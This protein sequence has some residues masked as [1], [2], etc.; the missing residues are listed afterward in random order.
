MIRHIA[1]DRADH[2][3]DAVGCTRVFGSVFVASGSFALAAAVVGT[4]GFGDATLLARLG[5]G[6]IGVAHLGGGL[7]LW[8][9]RWAGAVVRRRGVEWTERRPLRP[10]RTRS[11]APSEVAWV[12]VEEG[13]DSDGDTT[14]RV[15]LELQTGERFPLTHQASPVRTVAED[16]AAAVARRLQIPA[17]L[18]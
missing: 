4:G 2:V 15:V 13:K 10:S 16:A 3:T 9:G 14:Y 17:R 1:T 12:R 18:A 5:V 7:A 6:V 11:L 8:G